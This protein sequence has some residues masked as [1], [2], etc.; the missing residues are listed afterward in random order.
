MLVQN[1][2]N[3]QHISC[4][5]SRS[6]SKIILIVFLTSSFRCPVNVYVSNLDQLIRSNNTFFNY[7]ISVVSVGLKS[8]LFC[9]PHHIYFSEDACSTFLF[10]SVLKC[11][12]DKHLDHL[13]PLMLK[14]ITI[15]L[16]ETTLLRGKLHF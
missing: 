7:Q 1:V 11:N 9:H 16:P 15:T 14:K 8:A 13:L 2:S 10:C 6:S 5:N 3:I 12:A 4:S